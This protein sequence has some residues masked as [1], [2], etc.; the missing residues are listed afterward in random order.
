MIFEQ[1]S[2]T[3]EIVLIVSAILSALLDASYRDDALVIFSIVIINTIIG[4]LQ[5]FK[6]ERALE[7]LRNLITPQAR[8]LR[9]GKMQVIGASDVVPGDILLI[10]EGEKIVADARIIVSSGLRVNQAILT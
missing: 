2:S 1:L 6:T 7:H 10:D 4:V 9:D 5:E 8:I 3:L